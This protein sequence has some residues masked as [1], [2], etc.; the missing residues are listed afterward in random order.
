MWDSE[1][2]APAD[3]TISPRGQARPDQTKPDQTR[4]Y[5]TMPYKT[6]PETCLQ[7]FRHS[8]SGL[9][10]HSRIVCRSS[11]HNEFNRVCLLLT[12]PRLCSTLLLRP[13]RPGPPLPAIPISIPILIPIPIL[14]NKLLFSWPRGGVDTLSFCHASCLPSWLVSALVLLHIDSALLC[15]LPHMSTCSCPVLSCPVL[16]LECPGPLC[17]CCFCAPGRKL[18]AYIRHMP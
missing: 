1:G 15:P 2:Q 6:T 5:H 17:C 16:S 13:A 18:F 3:Y 12:L 10:F 8:Q 14:H 7:T 11:V 9:S 4:P